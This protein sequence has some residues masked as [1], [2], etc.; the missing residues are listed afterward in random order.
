MTKR[1]LKSQIFLLLV[2]M[3]L[4]QTLMTVGLTLLQ[5]HEMKHDVIGRTNAAALEQSDRLARSAWLMCKLLYSHTDQLM[6]RLRAGAEADI[7]AAGGFRLEGEEEYEVTSA[8][9]GEKRRIRL[10]HVLYG[11]TPIRLNSDPTQPVP[12]CDALAR[13]SGI[14]V[15]L[16]QRMNPA[17]DMLRLA[18][19]WLD[20]TGQRPTGTYQTASDPAWQPIVTSIL[21]G[22]EHFSMVTAGNRKFAALFFPIFATNEKRQEVIGMIGLGLDMADV[23]DSLTASLATLEDGNNGYVGILQAGSAAETPGNSGRGVVVL[24]QTGQALYKRGDNLWDVAI[25]G[26][27]PVRQVINAALTNRSDEPAR[28]HYRW[29]SAPGEPARWK[30]AGALYFAPFDWCIFAGVYDDAFRDIE[31]EMNDNLNLMLIESLGGSLLVLLVAAGL[32]QM[33]LR[34]IIRPID[35]I[36]QTLGVIATGDLVTARENLRDEADSTGIREAAVLRDAAGQM[37]G[38]L[39]ALVQQAQRSS[40]QLVSSANQIRAT[41]QAQEATMEDF[42]GHVSHVAAAI[43][44]ISATAQELSRTMSTLKDSASQAADLAAT[45]KDGISGLERM[46]SRLSDETRAVTAK[47]A[48]INEKTN[49][50]SAVVTTITKVAEQTNLLSLNAAIEAEKA[51]EYGLGFAVVAREIRH[52]ADQTAVATL[53][54]ERMVKETQSSVAVGVME[55][56]RFAED[57]RHSVQTGAGIGEQLAQVI[58]RVQELTPQFEK[59]SDGMQMQSQGARQISESMTQLNDAAKNLAASFRE[60]NAAA[61][62]LR[63]SADA[64]KDEVTRFKVS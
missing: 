59:V 62:G 3:L 38:S 19:T 36:T 35:R 9:T 16:W 46:M 44:E 26:D 54:I 53:D 23:V 50:I 30:N 21:A 11:Q 10:P 13:H 28:V 63:Q 18:A 27:Y 29:R 52:L 2:L 48:L 17:G 64:M 5:K 57:V 14:E 56:D 41:S 49:N 51:G 60:F 6:H 61:D 24:G 43:R 58:N 20:T 12:L 8:R 7:Q 40:V 4:L 55:M 15:T 1:P 45:G 32:A 34:R 33:I 42:G 39:L 25:D 31:D 47:L 22:R 37:T